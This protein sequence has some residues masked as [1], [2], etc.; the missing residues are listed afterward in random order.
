MKVRI[1]DIEDV[2]EKN[3]KSVIENIKSKKFLTQTS[4]K[5]EIL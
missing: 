3:V 4:R 5:F 1:S 2:I